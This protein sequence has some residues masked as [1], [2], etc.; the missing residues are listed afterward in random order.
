MHRSGPRNDSRRWDAAPAEQLRRPN[1]RAVL[2]AMIGSSAAAV[3]PAALACET[4]SNNG[5]LAA[6]GG[7]EFVPPPPGDVARVPAMARTP[8]PLPGLPPASDLP[9]LE[10][11]VEATLSR[12]RMVAKGYENWNLNSWG[13]GFNRGL[14]LMVPPIE[15]PSLSF[16]T[17]IGTGWVD[18]SMLY[19]RGIE[20]N[21]KRP[22]IAG[23]R[24]DV[25]GA[26]EARNQTRIFMGLDV[27]GIDVHGVDIKGGAS[28]HTIE[29]RALDYVRLA[30]MKVRGR[31]RGNG[32]FIATYP[33]TLVLEDVEMFGGGGDGLHHIVYINGIA[34]ADVRNSR[35]HSPFAEGHV[36]KC[37]ARELTLAG[38]LFATALTDQ[39]IA[40]GRFGD[41]PAL[42][43]G[44]YANSTIAFNRIV[45]AGG[46]RWP[47]IDFRNRLHKMGTRR[48]V[49]KHMPVWQT[50]IPDYRQVD[51]RNE[52]DPNLLRHLVAFND[53]RNGVMP[54]GTPDPE[55]VS[56][57]GYAIRNNSAIVYLYKRAAEQFTVLDPDGNRKLPDWWKQHYDPTV[58]YLYDNSCYGVPFAALDRGHPYGRPA[59]RTAVRE[60][61]SLPAWAKARLTPL[62]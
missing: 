20:K 14:V 38:N 52:D 41:L 61:E 32:L 62:R 57:P 60:L 50:P 13:R 56:K 11:N 2:G 48:R 17:T 54:D 5:L 45:R 37:Y 7:G 21:G 46:A 10:L 55:V 30:K 34:R 26:L 19:L 16:K 8:G 12:R 6:V 33:T 39:D 24:A 36:F 28:K 47:L 31:K 18:G 59:V 43:I 53:F 15:L 40:M 4:R 35:F 29:P 51:N 58:V 22:V 27:E 1:R 49:P 42:D 3:M 25:G 44:S 23:G 9:H